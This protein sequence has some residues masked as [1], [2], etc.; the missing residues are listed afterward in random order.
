MN[1]KVTKEEMATPSM[2][3]DVA[4]LRY[5]LEDVQTMVF[6]LSLIRTA[7][8]AGGYLSAAECNLLKAARKI[9]IS[10]KTVTLIDKSAAGMV[11]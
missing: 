7:F 9:N 10:Q 4:V 8:P 5:P 11:C 3:P 2:I 6:E 1:K